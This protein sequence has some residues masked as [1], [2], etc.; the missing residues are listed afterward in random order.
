MTLLVA[1]L[2]VRLWLCL[3]RRAERRLA[4]AYDVLVDIETGSEQ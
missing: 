2:R 3:S 4:S 1:R